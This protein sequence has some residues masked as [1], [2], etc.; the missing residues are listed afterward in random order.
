MVKFRA[1]PIDKLPHRRLATS[2][3]PGGHQ[4]Q[5]RRPK[6]SDDMM[7]ITRTYIWVS[8]E[9]YLFIYYDSADLLWLPPRMI[10]GRK[11]IFGDHREITI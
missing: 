5:V 9:P 3:Y 4:S 1:G 2:S 7:N 6:E 8:S 10:G 11:F